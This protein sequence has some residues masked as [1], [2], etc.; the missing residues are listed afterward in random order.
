M[1]WIAG[2]VTAAQGFLAW[3]V[4]AGIKRGRKLD[5]ALV[6]SETPATAVGLFT[7]NLVQ[8]APV[9]LSKARL[10]GGLARAVLLNSGSANCLTGERGLQDA[11]AISRQ[12]ADLLGEEDGRVLVAS[13]GLIGTR[14]PVPKIRRAI[15]ALVRQ[16]SRDGHARAARAILTTDTRTKEVAVADRVAG[17]RCH[18]GGMAK[19][20]G[21]IA[22]NL[23]T[24]LCV[25]TTDAAVDRRLLSELLRGAVAVSFNEITIDGDMSTNDAV[26]L[27]ANGRSGVTIRRHTREAGQFD[28]ML[29][30]VT[31]RLK[32]LLVQD[33]EGATCMATIIVDGARTSAE[34]QGC[35]RRVACSPLVKIMLSGGDPNVGRIAAAVGASG[36]RFDPRK[37][38]I[39]IGGV[40]TVVRRGAIQP[41]NVSAARKA[42]RS[43]PP[44]HPAIDID[45]HAGRARGRVTTCDL[46]EE[47][48]R[49]NARYST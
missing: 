44:V 10:R 14:L 6:A 37:L 49:I 16:L 40:G 17:A 41:F 18:L 2:G 34:A 29:S 28:R 20:A 36:A 4:S 15:P 5:L 48:V 32:H 43:R 35:A 27:L 45:L 42:L 13:T 47:Y 11:R 31:Q 8:A 7:S 24:M 9:Q 46:T 1:K 33:G 21:M 39:G 12:V 38:E 23:A 30:L 22:P 25:L 19:G 26:F 3:G